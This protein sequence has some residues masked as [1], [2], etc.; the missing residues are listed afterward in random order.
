MLKDQYLNIKE[1]SR[2]TNLGKTTLYAK[3][4]KILNKLDTDPNNPLTIKTKGKETLYHLTVL[5][6]LTYSDEQVNLNKPN[7]SNNPLNDKIYHE[8]E[9]SNKDIQYLKEQ[10]DVKNKIIDNLEIN[11]KNTSRLT[12]EKDNF[13]KD[14]TNRHDTIILTMSKQL[15]SLNEKLLMIEDKT[16]TTEGF[17][18][19]YGHSINQALI[20][21]VI[22]LIYIK[23]LYL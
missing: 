19:N 11:L 8:L 23:I 1:L 22:V 6:T 21:L 2:K 16:K 18:K 4:K 15:E 14:L 3:I 17:F 7:R 5:N 9:I 13:I 20:F 12:E 10:L